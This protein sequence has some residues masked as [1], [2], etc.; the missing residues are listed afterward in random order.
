M[1]L[2]LA[3]RSHEWR[4]SNESRPEHSRA[5]GDRGSLALFSSEFLKVVDEL[6][7]LHQAGEQ[8]PDALRR[9]V[10]AITRTCSTGHDADVFV[11]RRDLTA[12]PP[13]LQL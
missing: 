13:V 2:W 7:F 11:P 12:I 9:V 10:N 8:G 5:G 6:E 1:A 4:G 3:G